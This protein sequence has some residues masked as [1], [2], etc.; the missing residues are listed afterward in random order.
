MSIFE[1]TSTS[2]AATKKLG[3]RLARRLKPGD[4][5]L[6]AAHL[7]AG[8]TTLVQ[9]LARALGASDK[10]MSPTFVVA[11]TL[12][13]RRWPLHHIDFYRLE[14][15]EILDLGIQDYLMGT[16]EIKPGILVIEWADRCKEI[17]PKKRI[18]IEMKIKPHSKDR[19]IR[20]KTQ[21]ERFHDLFGT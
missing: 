4:V 21:G 2:A 1:I 11:Q 15:K 6:L 3:A 10:A 8:K 14:K 18:L 5:V 12:E 17:W 7:G 16:G 20:I 9:G 13:G 19:L